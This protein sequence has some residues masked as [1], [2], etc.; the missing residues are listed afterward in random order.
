MVIRR[1]LVLFIAVWEQKMQDI[2]RNFLAK[3]V[4]E[5]TIQAT[6]RNFLTKAASQQYGIR[7]QNNEVL[8]LLR[9]FYKLETMLA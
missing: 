3:A 7:G 4:W 5:P 6:I 8:V 9:W 1:S 2:I